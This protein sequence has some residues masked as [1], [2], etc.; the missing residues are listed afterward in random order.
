V[1]ESKNNID[2]ALVMVLRRLLSHFILENGR[3]TFGGTESFE[4]IIL[5]TYNCL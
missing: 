3:T 2:V 4:Q 1:L 5:R